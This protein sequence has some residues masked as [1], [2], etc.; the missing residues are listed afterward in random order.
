MGRGAP[1]GDRILFQR[2]LA[3]EDD[4]D[5]YVMTPDGDDL[6][7]VTSGPAGDTDASWSPDGES[8]V[9]SSDYGE[10]ETP[11]LFLISTAGGDPVRL[12]CATGQY[13]GAPSW[14][15]DGA[16]VAFESGL[17]DEDEPTT[18]WLIAVPARAPAAGLNPNAA[19]PD[20]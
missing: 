1:R 12:T 14:S 4:W 18:L 8:I 7:A 5:L 16:T 17:G 20:A 11:S 13:D 9:Y 6:E 10:L 2:R 19:C 3:D 15:P